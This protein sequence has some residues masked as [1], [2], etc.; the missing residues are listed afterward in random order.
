MVPESKIEIKGVNYFIRKYFDETHFY[1]K[2]LVEDQK[3]KVPLQ[4][5]EKVAK[6]SFGDFVDML[7]F[8]EMQVQEVFGDYNFHEYDVKKSPRMIIIAKKMNRVIS[9]S[10]L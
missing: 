4:F 9:D 8:G 7:S 2:I 10:T 6:F 3:L 1:K 5:I